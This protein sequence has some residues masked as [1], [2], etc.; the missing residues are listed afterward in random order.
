MA[1]LKQ[2]R[3]AA[4]SVI[5]S[6]ATLSGLA[7]GGLVHEGTVGF[8]N[9]AG[10]Y[11]DAEVELF[12]HSFGGNVAVGGA[13]TLYIRPSADDT[14]YADSAAESMQTV[15]QFPLRSG[16]AAAQKVTRRVT[17]LPP[18]LSR[19]SLGNSS[20]Q[21]VAANANSYVK[22]RGIRPQTA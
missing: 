14:T 7:N 21:A 18:G 6:G 10:G 15:R 3:E 2:E 4:Q 1:S 13:M 16:D 17:G 22:I 12:V 9:R 20:G 19:F 11:M 5:I 8:D